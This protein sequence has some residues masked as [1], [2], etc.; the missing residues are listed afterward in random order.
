[1]GVRFACHVCGKELN[2]KSELAGKRGKCP[3]CKQRFRIP[4]EDQPL[5]IP[6]DEPTPLIPGGA[7][8]EA[9]EDEVTEQDDYPSTENAATEVPLTEVAAT[10][11]PGTENAELESKPAS[12]PEPTVE[13]S[14]A[15]FDPLAAGGVLWYVRPPGGG[16]Y[17]PADGA[18]IRQWIGEGRVT[19]NTLLWREGWAQWRE[20]AEMLPNDFPKVEVE[21][22]NVKSKKAARSQPPITEPNKGT[23][24]TSEETTGPQNAYP[25]INVGMQTGS[26]S[27]V[28]I[29]AST[30]RFDP[31]SYLGAKKRR[32]ARQRATL[33]GILVGTAVLLVIA[34][35]VAIVWSR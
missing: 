32:K 8:D 24:V 10:G 12:H 27:S 11:N 17:G 30:D 7:Y 25:T 33:I 16:R 22:A 2:I 6:L 19:A 23:D 26:A 29:P 20:C 4:R 14:S 9:E 13:E 21:T 31:D 3:T 1:M 5:S 15:N 35:V 28:K 34:L 18:T